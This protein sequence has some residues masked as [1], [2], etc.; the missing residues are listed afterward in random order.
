MP[1][2]TALY[3]E[4]LSVLN[5]LGA[6]PLAQEQAGVKMLRLTIVASSANA[7]TV[8]GPVML[9]TAPLQCRN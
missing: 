3:H 4:L 6:L 1:Q 5:A 2:C 8:R 9:R 7:Q